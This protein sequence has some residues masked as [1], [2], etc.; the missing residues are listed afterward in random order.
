ML[1]PAGENA[2]LITYL[3]Y[4]DLSAYYIRFIAVK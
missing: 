1:S 3:I 4:I 2:V